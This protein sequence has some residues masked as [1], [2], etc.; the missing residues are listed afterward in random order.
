MVPSSLI[1]APTTFPLSSYTRLSLFP[2]TLAEL[3]A[4]IAEVAADATLDAAFVLF[5][6]ASFFLAVSFFLED[7]FSFFSFF[8]VSFSSS[9]PL[10]VKKFQT[11]FPAFLIP[12]QAFFPV[13]FAA[14]QTLPRA[15]FILVLKWSL[16]KYSSTV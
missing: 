11:D 7:F 13:S 16:I 1:P 5:C 12:S 6:S 10:L 3:I 2:A 8:S 14:S 4:D 9:S 15:F